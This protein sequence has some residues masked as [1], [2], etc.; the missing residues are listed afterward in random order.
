MQRLGCQLS[1]LAWGR[2]EAGQQIDG[3]EYLVDAFGQRV[4][5]RL[6][7]IL[8]VFGVDLAL[9]ELFEDAFDAVEPVVQPPGTAGLSGHGQ[10]PGDVCQL[11]PPADGIRIP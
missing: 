10:P 6:S 3:A 1:V 7:P 11:R 2:D 9:G 4:Q 5:L 8:A